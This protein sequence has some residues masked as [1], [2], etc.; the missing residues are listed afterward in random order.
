MTQQSF[1]SRR[2]DVWDNFEKMIR[3]GRKYL[4][5][6]AASFPLIY[7]ELTGDL[8]TA[9]ALGYD[10][11]IIERLNTLVLEGNQLLY[12]SRTFSLKGAADFIIRTFPRAVRSRRYSL[13]VTMLIFYGIG[14]FMF[15]SVFS[16]N[17]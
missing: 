7:R 9:R 14:V 1:I 3:G 16:N 4:V 10:P 8:N 15:F 13:A 17:I 6:N 11:S 12:G 5:E 2:K